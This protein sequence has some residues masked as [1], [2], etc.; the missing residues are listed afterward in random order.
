[1]SEALEEQQQ[2]ENI[3]RMWRDNRKWIINMIIA[4]IIVYFGISYYKHHKEVRLSKASEEYVDLMNAVSRDD[5]ELA[6]IKSAS[7][8][9]K[10]NYTVYGAFARLVSAKLAVDAGDWEKAKQQ[11]TLVIKERE[12][13]EIAALARLRLGKLMF[14]SMGDA[15]GALQ[16]L[17]KYEDGYQQLFSEL[18]G[19]IY[20]SLGEYELAKSSY[21][22]ATKV[23]SKQ[24]SPF[25][26]VKL[27]NLGH[28]DSNNKE[29]K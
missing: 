3:M 11:Y 4:C 10:Y 17:S 2:V 21:I 8:I 25:L 24:I 13:T 15:K 20:I 9:E 22:D 26:T 28:K 27:M 19:D 12:N 29:L 5:S 23:D 6:Q 18:K 16:I 14:L 1:M 7:M